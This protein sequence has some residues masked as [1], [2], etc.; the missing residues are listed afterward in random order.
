MLPCRAGAWPGGRGYDRGDGPGGHGR[1]P[2]R[3]NRDGPAGTGRP[4]H[5]WPPWPRERQRGGAA[6]PQPESGSGTQQFFSIGQ[7]QG[8]LASTADGGSTWALSAP[9]AGVGGVIDV[10]CPDTSTCFALGVEQTG[11]APGAAQVVLLTNT[12]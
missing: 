4:A 12:S 6:E 5:G 9:P 1:L 11:S 7:A 2:A 3:T 10:T 8:L